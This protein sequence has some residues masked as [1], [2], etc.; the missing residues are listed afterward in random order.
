MDINQSLS[1][2]FSDIF[3]IDRDIKLAEK[4]SRQKDLKER[5]NKNIREFMENQAKNA[6]KGS[7]NVKK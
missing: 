5:T 1:N 3:D 4:L 6:S 2:E 7:S